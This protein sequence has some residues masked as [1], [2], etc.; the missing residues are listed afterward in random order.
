MAHEQ[1]VG[2]AKAQI[3]QGKSTLIILNT[4]ADAR[5]VYE[6]CKQ[7]ECEKAFLT[8]DLCPAHRLN[9]LN[10]L[11]ENLLPTNKRLTLCVSTQLIEAGVDVSFNCV[12][13]A[14][15]SLDSIIQAAG[16][17]NRNKEN[18]TPQ[19]VFVVEV[20]DEKLSYLP[21][22]KDGK[23][24]TARVFRE[25]KGSNL[26][27]K[28][29]IGLFYDYYFY[30]QKDKMDYKIKGGKTTVYS[31]L[32]DNPLGTVAYR[33]RNNKG[34]KGLPCAFQTAAEAFS[35]IDGGQT[36]VVVPY[37]DALKLVGEFQRSYDPKEKMRILKQLQKFTVSVYSHTLEKLGQAISIVDN[38][39]LLLSSDYYD[40][41]E[42]GLL[43]EAKFSFYCV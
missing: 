33:N 10:R 17:C 3:E 13:R 39:F 19:P 23:E 8:T 27:S 31:L 25:K 6:Q 14:E 18:S 26:L 22:I 38:T 40:S 36:G 2:L 15:A 4:K 28:E 9:I 7:F 30:G 1:I 24:V 12:I 16:R 35:V 20:Q 32:S 21:E 29:V 34:Y 42:Q 11:R 5:K 37:G 43:L 41:K